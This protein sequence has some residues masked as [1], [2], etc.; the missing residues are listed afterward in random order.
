VLDESGEARTIVMGSYGIGLER[1]LAAIIET[2]HDERGI[3]WP[4]QVAPYEVVVVVLKMDDPATVAEGERI[5][6]E[7][8]AAGIDVIID[9]RPERPGVKFNDAELVGFPYRITVGPRSL[10]ESEAELTERATGETVRVAVDD[11]VSRVAATVTEARGAG[12]N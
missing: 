11:V 2:H 7:L 6:E 12:T 1:N 10:A 4:V 9:D 3:V 8:G 5:Y